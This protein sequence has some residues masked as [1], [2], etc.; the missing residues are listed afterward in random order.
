MS[1]KPSIGKDPFG[2]FEVWSWNHYTAVDKSDWHWPNFTPVEMRCQG[3]GRL[4]ISPAFMD[5]IQL[6]R[7]DSGIVMPVSSGYRSPEHN[8]AVSHTGSDEG[9]HPSCQAID[10]VIGYAN[11]FDLLSAALAHG[12]TGIGVKQHG[13]RRYLHLDKWHKRAHGSV[14]TYF[15][16]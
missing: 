7:A 3:S 5:D 14:W 13:Q 11:A 8:K 16:E 6:L 2:D 12:F 10:V 15:K 4:V 9:P 1:A